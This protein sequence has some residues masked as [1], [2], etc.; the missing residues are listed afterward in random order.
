VLDDVGWPSMNESGP[1]LLYAQHPIVFR[2]R[3]VAVVLDKRDARQC[4][5][6][7]AQDKKINTR[8]KENRG[9]SPTGHRL[10]ILI[11]RELIRSKNPGTGISRKEIRLDL[12]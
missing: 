3:H 5:G 2:M 1:A 7:V 8:D 11:S 6:K 4:I 10:S 12:G 9:E